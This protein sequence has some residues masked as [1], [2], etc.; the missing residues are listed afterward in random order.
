LKRQ[1]PSKGFRLS[2]V[3]IYYVLFGTLKYCSMKYCSISADSDIMT[4]SKSES[5][6][7][8]PAPAVRGAAGASRG[9][10]GQPGPPRPPGVTGKLP[11]RRGI[12]RFTVTGACG[13]YPALR[14]PRRPPRSDGLGVHCRARR[15][16]VALRL[17]CRFSQA[18]RRSPSLALAVRSH[19]AVAGK[20][21]AAGRSRLPVRR[22]HWHTGRS[23]KFAFQVQ[24]LKL[25]SP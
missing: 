16:S 24:A 17:Y 20:S 21:A 12:R 1:T 2:E 8:S 7:E 11:R 19:A 6:S 4:M 22:R 9:S 13:Q 23:Y 15:S 14:V 5:E 3:A 18:A 25:D 10:W